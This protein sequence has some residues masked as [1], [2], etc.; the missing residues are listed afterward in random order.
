MYTYIYALSITLSIFILIH[1]MFYETL[2]QPKKRVQKSW[3]IKKTDEIQ[4]VH[5]NTR[6]YTPL[7][8]A[9]HVSHTMLN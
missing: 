7:F 9:I 2:I 3:L 6:Y 1:V 4:N 8:R 5:T